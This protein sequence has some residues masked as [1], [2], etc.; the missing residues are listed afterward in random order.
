MAKYNVKGCDHE[1]ARFCF[2]RLASTSA[3]M[4]LRIMNT[5]AIQADPIPLRAD[6]DGVVRIGGTRVTLDTVVVAFQNGATP[7]TVVDQYPSLRL[8]DVYS[9]LGYFLRH[10]DEVDSY[11]ARRATACNTVRRD[12]EARFPAVGV[13]ERL[14]ARQHNGV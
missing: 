9:T 12:N 13:R 2:W 7:E 10:R 1:S 3:I 4:I 6:A 5:L 14:M 11:L 8:D